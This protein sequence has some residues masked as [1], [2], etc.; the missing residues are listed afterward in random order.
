MQ[1]I[2]FSEN[3]NNKLLCKSFSTLRLHNAAKYTV[4]SQYEIYYKGAL[5]GKAEIVEKRT[6]EGSHINEFISQIDTG[7]TVADFVNLLKT[8]YK[9]K[10]NV[11]VE[12]SKWDYLCLKWSCLY[13]AYQTAI[14]KEYLQKIKYNE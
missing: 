14:V 12:S 7:Y 2:E 10:T 4:G 1:K 5:I 3:W 6:F 9:N 13:G 8:M 11:K